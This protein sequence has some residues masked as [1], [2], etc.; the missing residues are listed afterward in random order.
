VKDAI[1]STSVC[2]KLY[3]LRDAVAGDDLGYALYLSREVHDKIQ[4]LINRKEKKGCSLQCEVKNEI[5]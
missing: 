4:E 3:K 5:K 1:E 2:E